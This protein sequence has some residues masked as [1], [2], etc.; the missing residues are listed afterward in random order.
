MAFGTKTTTA[1]PATQ[2]A[3][4][5]K[6]VMDSSRPLPPSL[7]SNSKVKSAVKSI[8]GVSDKVVEHFR[9]PM[10]IEIM[11][12]NAVA[13]TVQAYLGNPELAKIHKGKIPS[14]D[15]LLSTEDLT[16]AVRRWVKGEHKVI[17][18]MGP[19]EI[20]RQMR[21]L[22]LDL[23]SSA[24]G[25]DVKYHCFLPLLNPT[26]NPAKDVLVEAAKSLHKAIP[27]AKPIV[28]QEQLVGEDESNLSLEPPAPAIKK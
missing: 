21:D 19:D 20:R 11:L 8:T 15:Q 12:S 10:P 9:K 14:L 26:A 7:V 25:S 13:K 22:Y 5:A 18:V 4:T 17:A 27:D 28:V 6:R 2:V 1:I 24:S 3:E 16:I 23:A